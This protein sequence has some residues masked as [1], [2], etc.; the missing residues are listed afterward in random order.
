MNVSFQLFIFIS[1]LFIF[2]VDAVEPVRTWTNHE[3]KTIEAR[4][5]SSTAETVTVMTMNGRTYILQNST[6][7]SEDQAYLNKQTAPDPVGPEDGWFTDAEEAKA[8]A[9]AH[10]RPLLMLF[11]GSDWCG[12]CIRLEDNVL[13]KSAWESFAREELVLLKVDFPRRKKISTS[14]REANQEIQRRYGIRGYPTMVITDDSGKKIH[15]FGYGGQP[16]SD[17]IEMVKGKLP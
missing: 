11:T 15:Q 12:Y 3:G 4:M 9:K 16:A 5:L 7:S 10:G 17:F 6:L 13:S 2:R 1:F 14:Q 8:V